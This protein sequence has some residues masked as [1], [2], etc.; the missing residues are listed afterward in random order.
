MHALQSDAPCRFRE[1]VYAPAGHTAH[2]TVDTL[3]YCPAVHAV[4]EVPP[5]A[6]NVLVTDPAGH[7]AHAVV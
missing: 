6:P 7:T 5:T 3:L 1:F 4:H 2:A